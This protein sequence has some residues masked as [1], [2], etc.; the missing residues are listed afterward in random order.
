VFQQI[1]GFYYGR[2]DI[3]FNSWE[4]LREGRNFSI[5]ELNGAGSEPTH[6][7]DP[8]HS[9]F[10]AWKEIIRHWK[11]LARISRANHQNG[12]PYM[13]TKEG[14]Q[15]LRANKAYLKSVQTAS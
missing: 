12:I 13:S 5:I 4:E 6:M 9:I 10:F 1:D 2:L 3:K 11:I 14:L 7:Y 8:R 15:L